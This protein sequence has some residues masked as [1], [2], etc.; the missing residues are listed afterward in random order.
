MITSF[1][2]TV[3]L[4]GSAMQAQQPAPQAD[5]YQAALA[6]LKDKEPGARRQG[7]N[8]LGQLRR[9]EAAP[10]LLEALKDQEAGVRAAAAGALGLMR[11]PAAAPPLG[12]LVV[13]DPDPGVRQN[14]AVSL[15]FIADPSVADALLDRL[16]HRAVRIELKGGSM[17]RQAPKRPRKLT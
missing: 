11:A 6:R 12:Q 17:R 14:A 4:S 5:P 8:E 3:L 16:V 15:A 9:P 7:A 2:L 1:L 10:V 13:S